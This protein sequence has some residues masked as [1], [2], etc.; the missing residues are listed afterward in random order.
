MELIK[1]RDAGMNS[2]TYFYVRE[3]SRA[4]ISPYFDSEKEAEDWYNKA[5]EELNFKPCK[6]LS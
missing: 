5:L 3:G 1:Y 6:D 4:V 2:Y